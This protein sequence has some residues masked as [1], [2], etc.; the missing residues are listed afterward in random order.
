MSVS[1]RRRIRNPEAVEDGRRLLGAGCDI[2]VVLL[3][4][5]DRSFDQADC[6]YAV[7]DLLG[8]RFS[9]AKKLVFLSRA[10]SDGFEQD[11]RLAEEARQALRHFVKSN[12][13]PGLKVLFDEDSR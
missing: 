8:V 13:I 1:V 9:E 7:E 10:W 11:S 2:E 6:I 4:L 5:R 12:S 3:L